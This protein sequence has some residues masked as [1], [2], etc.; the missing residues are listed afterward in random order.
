[1]YSEQHEVT[2]RWGHFLLDDAAY[3]AYLEGKLWINWGADSVREKPKPSGSPK[4]YIPLNVSEEAVRL[5][6]AAAHQDVYL[7][8]QQRFPGA[9]VPLPYK[10][11]M[12][13]LSIEEMNL[14]VRSS[15]A[16]MRANAKTFERVMEIMQTENGFKLIRNLG[17]K[18]EKEIIR[19]FFCACYACL[20]QSEQAAFWQKVIDN[21]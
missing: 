10:N 16:L 9:S 12:K 21:N 7:L 6:D 19:N 18:S 4:P 20:S 14:S 17:I 2:T 5:R 1:M 8:L 13:D 11:R 3:A 15:N